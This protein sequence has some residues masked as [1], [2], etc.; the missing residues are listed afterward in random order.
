MDI[1][2]ISINEIYARNGHVNLNEITERNKQLISPGWYSE[3]RVN[4][5]YTKCLVQYFPIIG[6]GRK[7][8]VFDTA[9]FVVKFMRVVDFKKDVN[10]F[11]GIPDL[12]T[13]RLELPISYRNKKKHIVFAQ[14]KLILVNPLEYKDI[15]H[16][17]YFSFY[18]SM[19]T[20]P[21]WTEWGWGVD[22]NNIPHVFS[23]S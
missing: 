18:E 5:H 8:L 19:D 14:E 15:I 3:S 11:D 6:Y 16:S 2:P 17:R 20:V 7:T 21:K 13:P 9:W 23:W 10:E 1:I 12:F 22:E 4:H